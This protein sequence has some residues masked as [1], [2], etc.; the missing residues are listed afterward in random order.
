MHILYWKTCSRQ[1]KAVFPSIIVWQ[2][3]NIPSCPFLAKKKREKKKK[4]FC[5]FFPSIWKLQRKDLPLFPES[6][7]FSFSLEK[8]NRKN[9]IGSVYKFDYCIK[10]PC[11][12]YSTIL[13]STILF[14]STIKCLQAFPEMQMA[15]VKLKSLLLRP[16]QGLTVTIPLLRVIFRP[17]KP[18]VW[19]LY[20]KSTFLHS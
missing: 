6:T 14:D 13:P 2:Y 9:R 11:S 20:I 4:S 17:E 7:F 1:K 8:K 3:G 16:S 19:S 5:L 10:G 15:Q 12:I 18:L